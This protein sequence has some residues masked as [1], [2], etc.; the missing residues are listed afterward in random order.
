MGKKMAERPSGSDPPGDSRITPPGEDMGPAGDT[1]IPPPDVS[2]L[3]QKELHVTDGANIKETIKNESQEVE[4]RGP[5][6]DTK[7]PPPDVSSSSHEG[8][9]T[10]V[11]GQTDDGQAVDRQTEGGQAVDGQTEGGQAVGGQAVGGQTEGG[12]TEGGQ[13][14]GGQ[15]EGGQAA[16]GQAVDG[17]TDIINHDTSLCTTPKKED[18]TPEDVRRDSEHHE[19]SALQN[20]EQ[21]TTSPRQKASPREGKT[22]DRE[23]EIE[24]IGFNMQETPEAIA[25]KKIN[26]QIGTY[27][28]AAVLIGLIAYLWLRSPPPEFSPQKNDAAVRFLNHIEKVETEFPN[29]RAEL[30]KRSRIHLKRHL[31]TAQPTEPVSLILT[32]GFR[33]EKT[34]QCL[35]RG[36][37]SA[38]SSTF[39]TSVLHINGSSKASHASDQVKLDIDREL[40]GAFEGGIPV[41][42]IH[43]FEELPP[44]STLIFYRYCDHENAAYK[45]TFLIFTVL[46]AE[47]EEIPA[48]IGLNAV[49]EMVDDHLQKKFLSHEHPVSYDVMDLDKYGGLWSRISHLIL[50]VAAEERIERE[51]CRAHA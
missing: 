24:N 38:F 9:T 45:D 14:E 32:A 7:I 49:E 50:P 27:F 22:E 16:G 34:L 15:T 4:D 28:V 47:E 19:A 43:R 18:V 10:T 25:T 44:G 13:T 11:D 12:Q 2:S 40:Q 51:G 29:Q 1:K 26:N 8:Q 48:Q 23:K 46:L 39:N 6:G 42:V 35:A 21:E 31:V 33:A 36:M 30:W 37:A 5:A 41:A 17:Q 20:S 3:P